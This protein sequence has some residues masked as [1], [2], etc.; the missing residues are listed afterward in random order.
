MQWLKQTFSVWFNITTWRIGHV[1]GDRY[2]SKILPGEPSPEAV[3][4]DWTWVK[5]MAEK[6]I[7]DFID[8]KLS[9]GAPRAPRKGGKP[10]FSPECAFSVSPGQGKGQKPGPSAEKTAL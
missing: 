5:E 2:K 10:G 1:W 7:A 6:E 9:W 8:Y 4:V 3:P